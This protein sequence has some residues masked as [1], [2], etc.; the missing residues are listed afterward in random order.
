MSIHVTLEDALDSRAATADGYVVYR[1][2]HASGADIL[3]RVTPTGTEDFIAFESAPLTPAVHYAIALGDEVAGLRL[4]GNSLELLD[5]KGTPRLRVVPP[6]L[7]D[8]DG[9]QHLA[10]LAVEDCGV[11][12]NPSA[13]HRRPVIA[14][15]S[16]RCVL[17]VSWNDRHVIY[18][19]LLDPVMRQEI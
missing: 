3:H 7:V 12:T 16:A 10:A 11:D 8:R 4:V 5:R 15:A 17:R 1:R 19:A 9:K 13:P 6:I 2:A 18:P 14:P